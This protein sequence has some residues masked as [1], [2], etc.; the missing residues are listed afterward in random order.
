VRYGL[1]THDGSYTLDYYEEEIDVSHLDT[2]AEK[3]EFFETHIIKK[4]H[5]RVVCMGRAWGESGHGVGL[6]GVRR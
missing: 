3:V 1:C 5:C 6:D 2:T 4:V